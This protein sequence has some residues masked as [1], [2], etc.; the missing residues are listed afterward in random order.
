MAYK[1]RYTILRSTAINNHSDAIKY[2]YNKKCGIYIRLL[3]PRSSTSVRLRVDLCYDFA[4][5]LLLRVL[6][7]TGAGSTGSGA[8]ATSSSSNTNFFTT[9]FSRTR[10]PT[11]SSAFRTLPRVS[12]RRAYTK[13]SARS[14]RCMEGNKRTFAAGVRQP[15]CAGTAPLFRLGFGGLSSRYTVV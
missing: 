6:F 12:R 8:A 10:P 13:Q 3:W 14:F 9:M 5:L 1:V 4:F 11:G 7:T 2:G 15:L